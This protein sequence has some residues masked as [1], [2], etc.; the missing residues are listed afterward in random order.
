MG[1]RAYLTLGFL[2]L[3]FHFCRSFSFGCGPGRT[4]GRKDGGGERTHQQGF[5][6]FP[7]KFQLARSCICWVLGR[8]GG[9]VGFSPL[10]AYAELRRSLSQGCFDLLIR[11]SWFGFGAWVLGKGWQ[12]LQ[13]LGIYGF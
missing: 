2:G 10:S 7:F 3:W 13:N 11:F 6:R 9:L 8:F 12:R 5:I 4:E 1:F